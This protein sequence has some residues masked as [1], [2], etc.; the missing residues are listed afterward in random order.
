MPKQK[1]EKLTTIIQ[2][3]T[4]D[5]LKQYSANENVLKLLLVLFLFQ[6]GSCGL[7][8]DKK[9]PATFYNTIAGWDIQHIPIIKPFLMTS[10]DRGRSWFLNTAKS[11]SINISRFGVSQNFIYGQSNM[12]WFV[13]DTKSK[14]YAEYASETEMNEC[15]QSFN[16]KVNE[17]S[18]C[19]DYFKKLAKGI[20]PY[21]FPADGKEYPDYPA[22]TPKEVIDIKITDRL[23]EEPD[24]TL[25]K[26]PKENKEGI[27]FFRILYSKGQNEL[28][29][30]SLNNE[31]PIPVKD[32]LLIPVFETGNMFEITLYTPY[33]IAEQ[34]GIPESK[35]LYK[36]KQ[37]FF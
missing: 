20:K 13:F 36:Q 31:Q 5:H 2:T 15:L 7:I 1:T 14:L 10:I 32:S 12:K 34:K 9:E 26:K 17:I 37:I 33:P 3:L 29:Y 19:N 24:F 28:Y 35:R 8:S 22:I 25:L 21:W 27:Y 4:A 6:F 23:N 16:I 18:E 11:G 30:F